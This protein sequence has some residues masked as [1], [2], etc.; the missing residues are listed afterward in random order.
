M[1]QTG[2]LRAVL[3]IRREVGRS[4]ITQ[5]IQLEAGSP[6]LTFDTTV[7]WQEDQTLL[8]AAFPVNIHADHA[9]YEVQFGHVRRS[10]H[11]N[12]TWDEAR[13]EV[14][15]QQ[16]AALTETGYGVALLNDCKYGYDIHGN[17]MRL[18]LLRSPRDPDPKA[19]L[20]RHNFRYGLYPFAG[21]LA[22]GRVVE[23][24]R[25]FNNPLVARACPVQPGSLPEL[26]S[27]LEIDRPGIMLS[28]LK[29]SEDGKG[30]IAR[31]YEAHGSRGQVRVHV[32]LPVKKAALVNMLEEEPQELKLVGRSLALELKP[33]E[34]VT[35]KLW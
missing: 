3:E 14:A 21:D 19:D 24:A 8:K 31:I 27:F 12:T 6:L 10:T 34:I 13:F 7:D 29:T 2:P 5:K 22:A 4:V 33:F 11:Y 20:G 35:V 17:T 15:A 25:A 30:W 26:Q 32:N 16:W 1:V 28:T 9:T 23:K 18:S